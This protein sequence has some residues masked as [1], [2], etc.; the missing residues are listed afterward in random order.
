[1]RVNLEHYFMWRVGQDAGSKDLVDTFNFLQRVFFYS[2]DSGWCLVV[3]FL[4]NVTLF[5]P[6][7]EPVRAFCG[8][9][10]L[11]PAA[12][13]DTAPQRICQLPPAAEMYN[14]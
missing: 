11:L 10:V 3:C 7:G 14:N 13:A 1:M 4:G 9:K 6:D 12:A 8:S 5:I 2:V